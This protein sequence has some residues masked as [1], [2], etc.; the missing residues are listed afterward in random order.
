MLSGNIGGKR[1]LN[2]GLNRIHSGVYDYVKRV[3]IRLKNGV[4]SSDYSAV[5]NVWF[6]V[7]PDRKYP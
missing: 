1:K 3:E 5:V 7:L 6:L 4:F 2:S